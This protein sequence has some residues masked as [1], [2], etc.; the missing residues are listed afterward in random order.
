[1]ANLSK[2]EFLM[3]GRTYDPRKHTVGGHY[4]SEKLEGI[5]VFWDGGISRGCHTVEVPW[6]C[7]VNPKTGSLKR[8]IKPLATG[9]WSRHG[10]PIIV[11]DWF[12]NLLPCMPLDGVI[13]AGRGNFQLCHSIC[14][15]SVPGPD[16]DKAEFAV[17]GTPPIDKIFRDGVIKNDNMMLKLLNINIGAWLLKYNPGI[18]Q[19]W[20][21]STTKSGKV[22]FDTELTMLRGAIPSE[23][24]VYLLY[25][26]R[27]PCNVKEAALA[28]EKELK[29]ILSLGGKGIIIRDPQGSWEP[30]QVSTTL[31]YAPLLEI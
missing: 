27:L 31:K 8:K 12:L 21:Y 26:K 6:A 30:R 19:D 9:L 24:R 4:I 16:W 7:I 1:M 29:R 11:A 5:R 13:W 15:G 28:V 2:R 23:G 17:F 18:I 22:T 10:N 20:E 3:Q 14:S 25:Q